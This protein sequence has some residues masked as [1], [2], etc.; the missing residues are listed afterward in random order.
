MMPNRLAVLDQATRFEPPMGSIPVPK[1]VLARTD[2]APAPNARLWYRD[3]GG[4]GPTVLL[5]HPATGSALIWDHQLQALSDAGYRA[6]CYSRRGHYG[7]QSIDSDFVSCPALDVA[8]LLDHLGVDQCSIVAAAAGCSVA[9]DFALSFQTRLTCALFSCGSFSGLKEDD[10]RSMARRVIVDGFATMPPEFLE[11]GPSYR[12]SNP[13]GTSL[14]LELERKAATGER[15]MV[16]SLNALTWDRLSEI[17]IPTLFFAGGADLYAPPPQVLEVV[18]HV[19][20]AR[21]VI[22]GDCGHSPHWETPT[23]FNHAMLDFLN[24]HAKAT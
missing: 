22:F 17:K 8:A 24:L 1:A 20:T 14:W 12:A 9:M 7:S 11:L 23:A 4:S 5:L 21:M 16:E 18:R 15:V 13:V 2:W 19:A 3:T 10:Y 6:I